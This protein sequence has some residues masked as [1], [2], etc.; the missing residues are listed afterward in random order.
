MT[1]THEIKPEETRPAATPRV[2]LGRPS[3]STGAGF[4]AGCAA[5]FGLGGLFLVVAVTAVSG[6]VLAQIDEM[7]QRQLADIEAERADVEGTHALLD[8]VSEWLHAA[9]ERSGGFPRALRETPPPDP[10]GHALRY[11][12]RGR[13]RADLRSA[14]PDGAFDTVDDVVRT[15]KPR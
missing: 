8:E 10:W 9:R 13:D 11:E 12:S 6:T 5:I 14:G 1:P 4:L 7:Q 2:P 3:V 15:L